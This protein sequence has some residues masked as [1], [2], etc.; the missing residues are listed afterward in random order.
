MYGE[1]SAT[2]LIF[3]A[4]EH[5]DGAAQTVFLK[6]LKRF[7]SGCKGKAP[8]GDVE[9]W[10]FPSFGKGRGFG[11]PDVLFLVG[12]SVFWVEVETTVDLQ[13]AQS[14]LGMALL[15]LLRFKLFQDAISKGT[16]P[17][18][19]SRRF[20]GITIGNNGQFRPAEVNLAGHKV[21]QTLWKRLQTAG[22]KNKAHYVLFT[23]RQPSGFGKSGPGYAKALE[24]GANGLQSSLGLH[25]QAGLPL[26]RCWYLYW[27]GDLEPKFNQQFPDTFD[28]KDQYVPK[29]GPPPR[30]T[31]ATKRRGGQPTKT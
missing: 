14:N 7:G 15:Q 5:A 3:Q 28:L 19:G 25:K 16:I 13:R 2:F 12:D 27:I 18:K 17:I 21:L 8:S 11:E 22:Q 6:N 29:K 10:L 26:K 20:S 23:I 31:S 30:R 4:L 24:Q 9:I 1:N